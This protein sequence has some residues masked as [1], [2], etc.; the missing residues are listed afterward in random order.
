MAENNGTVWGVYAS[1]PSVEDAV[2]ILKEAGVRNMDISVLFPDEAGSEAFAHHNGTKAPEGFVSDLGTGA[3][4]G[5]TLGWLM[6]IGALTIPGLG[7]VVAAGPVMAALAGLGAGSTLG[8]IAGALIAMGVREHQANR[9]E[10]R[11]KEGAILL[12][13]H[14]ANAGG[15]RRATEIMERTGAQEIAST[16]DAGIDYFQRAWTPARVPALRHV[17]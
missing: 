2:E 9:Y 6:G 16:G 12:S 11:V 3:V 7:L 14:S 17:N 15:S 5:G 1:Y 13:V 10:V 8:G 4:V